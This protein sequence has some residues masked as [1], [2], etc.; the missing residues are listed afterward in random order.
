MSDTVK[1]EFWDRLSDI[2]SGMLGTTEARFVPMSHYVDPDKPN[3]LWFITAKDTDLSKSAVSPTSAQFI[4]TSKDEALYARIDGTLSQS[5]DRAELES[6][7]T[8][9]RAPGSMK[10]SLT[11]TCS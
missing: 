11:R 10:A 4:V 5:H 6:C 7:G 1:K 8:P 3:T 9:S 2:T